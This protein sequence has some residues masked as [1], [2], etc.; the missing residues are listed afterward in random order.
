MV[1]S[2]PT[3]RALLRRGVAAAGVAAASAGCSGLLSSSGDGTDVFSQWLPTPDAFGLDEY[4]FDYYDLETLATE[5]ANLGGEP[6]VFERT[7][8]PVGVD[9]ED[10]TAVVTVGS[11]DVVT[12]SFPRADAESALTDAGYDEGGTYRG[13]TI[14]RNGSAG[15]AVAVTEGTL[16]VSAVGQD[17]AVV[18]GGPVDR[19]ETVVDAKAGAVDRY[20]AT[21]EDMRTLVDALG[22][23]TLVDGT[24][25]AGPEDTAPKGGRF[26]NL[27][28]RGSATEIAGD[29]TE[30]KWV[31]VYD[32]PTDVDLDV[33]RRYVEANRN[34]SARASDAFGT[35][36]EI[37]YTRTGR[38]GI[39]SGTRATGEYWA[40]T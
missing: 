36:E 38:K 29:R 33:L 11:V 24:T 14:F 34:G 21:D 17:A 15:R 8:E 5:A 13:Y 2:E 26:R 19:I 28:A 30:E 3:R 9:W 4:W 10:T 16:L 18:S 1:D 37:E 35:V 7:W 22:G 27:V 25:L 39:I 23:A 6:D 20:A 32:S 40:D 31:Y 12:A